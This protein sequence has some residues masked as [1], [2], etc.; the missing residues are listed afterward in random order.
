MT[1]LDIARADLDTNRNALHLVL[2][3]LPAGRVFA[4]VKLDSYAACLEFF[5]D[6]VSLVENALLVLSNGNDNDLYGSYGR[7]Y[8]PSHRRS[9]HDFDTQS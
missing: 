7:R 9:Y 3:E 8:D 5:K 2:G 4:V 1:L 6:L